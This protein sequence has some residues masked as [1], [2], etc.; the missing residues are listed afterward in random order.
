MECCA[1]TLTL[2]FGT[3]ETAELSA[4]RAGHTLR[5]RKILGTVFCW[6]LRRLVAIEQGQ[7]E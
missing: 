6:R 1:S 7:T 3:T 4:V 5:Q 2:T